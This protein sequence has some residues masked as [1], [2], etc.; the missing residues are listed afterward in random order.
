[1]QALAEYRSRVCKEQLWNWE[2]SSNVLCL[3]SAGC[4]KHSGAR[5]SQ[6]FGK[7]KRKMRPIDS[8]FYFENWESM[9]KEL[10]SSIPSDAAMQHARTS[11]CQ[12]QFLPYF[13]PRWHR[14]ES[15][16]QVKNLNFSTTED[17]LKAAFRKCQG[18]RSAVIMRK[19]AAVKKG[20]K[21]DPSCIWSLLNFG[22]F[23]S[24]LKGGM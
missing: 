20:A 24:Q 5:S 4:G 1:M 2:E 16:P 11:C 22:A 13:L 19:K 23:W 10:S 8:Q 9:V 18:F 3:L 15:S 14:H 7:W 21:K 17:S 6:D 12:A